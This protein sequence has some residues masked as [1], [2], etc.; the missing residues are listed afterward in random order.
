MGFIC[1]NIHILGHVNL[2]LHAMT[3]GDTDTDRKKHMPVS[4]KELI[5]Y[6]RSAR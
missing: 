2:E 4:W 5:K 6:L 3:E 1:A